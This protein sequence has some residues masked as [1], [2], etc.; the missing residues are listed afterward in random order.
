MSEKE[1][2][3]TNEQ[4]KRPPASSPAKQGGRYTGENKKVTAKVNE[5]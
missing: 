5:Q 1:G 3:K 2:V 4:E